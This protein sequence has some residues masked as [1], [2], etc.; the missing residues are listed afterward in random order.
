MT[1]VEGEMSEVPSNHHWDAILD[2][3]AEPWPQWWRWGFG[4]TRGS[5][6]PR[7]GDLLD[8]FSL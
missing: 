4:R 5:A 2:V 6:E 8:F 7:V 1:V 3:H